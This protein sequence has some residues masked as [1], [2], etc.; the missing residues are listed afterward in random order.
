MRKI[1]TADL[2]EL[3]VLNLCGGERLGYPSDFELDLDDGR[4]LSLIVS[5]G[6]KVFSIFGDKDEYLIPW[7]KIECIGEDAILVRLP[8]EELCSCSKGKCKRKFK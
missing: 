6:A 5:G 7:C 2:R 1:S 4:I 3:E 8:R